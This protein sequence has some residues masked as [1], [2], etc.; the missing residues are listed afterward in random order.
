MDRSKSDEK[1]EKLDIKVN[2]STGYKLGTS[3]L[4]VCVHTKR[5]FRG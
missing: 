2:I 4:R 1:I 3:W 5:V